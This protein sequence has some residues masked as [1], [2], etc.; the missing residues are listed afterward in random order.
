MTVKQ[1]AS[2]DAVNEEKNDTSKSKQTTSSKS[3]EEEK[4]NVPLPAVPRAHTNANGFVGLSNQGATCYLNS[5]LQSL[6]NTPEIREMVYKWKYNPEV[7]ASEERCIPLQ[8]QKLFARLQ[9]SKSRAVTTKLL[10]ASF[11]WNR[12]Q[13]FVQH[14]VQELCR[15]L[16][17]ALD[18]ALTCA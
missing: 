12:Q 5:L 18:K 9:L 7:E 1:E 17:D 10:T 4:T 11:G 15:I 3:Q 6:Y 16:F 2:G 13:A 8:L 14:D